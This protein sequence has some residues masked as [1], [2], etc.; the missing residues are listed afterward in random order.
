M[1]SRQIAYGRRVHV[2]T[3]TGLKILPGGGGTTGL[4][5]QE[6]DQQYPYCYAYPVDHAIHALSEG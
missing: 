2:R 6:H 5:E 3:C 4:P 1:Q